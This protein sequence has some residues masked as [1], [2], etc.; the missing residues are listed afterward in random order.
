MATVT[1]DTLKFVERLKAAGVPEAQAK[2]EAE[3]L[4]LALSEAMESQLATKVDVNRIERELLVIKW[5]I[6]LALGG[7][8]TLILKAFF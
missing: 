6:G 4:A 3:A 5:M 2:A 7:I 8:V 1:F